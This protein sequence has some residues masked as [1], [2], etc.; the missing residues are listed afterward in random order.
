MFRWPWPRRKQGD[1]ALQLQ[2]VVPASHL[3]APFPSRNRCCS[4]FRLSAKSG[5][6]VVVPAKDQRESRA[7]LEVTV[8]CEPICFLTQE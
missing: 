7:H 8:A 3:Q 6:R 5:P 4:F 1:N 2:S